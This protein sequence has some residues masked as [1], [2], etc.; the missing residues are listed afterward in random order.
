MTSAVIPQKVKDVRFDIV[1]SPG[2]VDLKVKEILKKISDC[3]R[4]CG[5]SA[6]ASHKT[7]IDIIHIHL[8]CSI[9]ISLPRRGTDQEEI[10][11]GNSGNFVY[12]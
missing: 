3:S 9:N 1:Q 7:F 2:V 8:F 11:G 6:L 5:E 12:L 4:I 10:A